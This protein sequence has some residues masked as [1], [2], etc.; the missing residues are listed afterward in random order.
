MWKDAIIK[1]L[2]EISKGFVWEVFDEREKF[3][4]IVDELRI[5]G[6]LK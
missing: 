6:N 1:E 4:I 5:N 2:Q 3:Q